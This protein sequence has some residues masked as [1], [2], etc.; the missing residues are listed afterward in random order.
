MT[1]LNREVKQNL[2]GVGGEPGALRTKLLPERVPDDVDMRIIECMVRISSNDDGCVPLAD[3]SKA[4][5]DLPYQKL[6]RR[7]KALARNG[8][9][10]ICYRGRSIIC[11]A[12]MWSCAPT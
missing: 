6:Y 5:S 7:V 1:K 3:L 2:V 10:R 8:D 9:I 11:R 12:P 4:F